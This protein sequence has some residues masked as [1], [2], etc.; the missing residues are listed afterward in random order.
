MTLLEFIQHHD[1][2][3]AVVV[4]VSVAAAWLTANLME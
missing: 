1:L 3:V 4:F 2:G